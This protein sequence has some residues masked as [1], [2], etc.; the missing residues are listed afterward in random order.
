MLMRQ[1]G[2]DDEE[3]YTNFVLFNYIP[4]GSLD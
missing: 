3:T 1:I 2:E 4:S